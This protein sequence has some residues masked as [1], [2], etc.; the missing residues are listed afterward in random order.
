V[1]CHPLPPASPDETD[2]ISVSTVVAEETGSLFGGNDFDSL[3]LDGDLPGQNRVPST[4]PS[5]HTED[6]ILDLSWKE[7]IWVTRELRIDISSSI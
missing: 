5:G 1:R 4:P 7:G 3:T 6:L 2:R